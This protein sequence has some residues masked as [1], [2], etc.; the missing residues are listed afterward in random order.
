[1]A[2]NVVVTAGSGTTVAADEV[3]DGT[4]GTVKV[5]FV[6]LMDGTLDGTAKATIKAAS[7]AAAAADPAFVVALSPNNTALG[8]GATSAATIRTTL[9]SDSAGI[10]ATGTQASPSA[11]YLS[12]V[13][14]GDIAHDGVDSGNPQKIGAKATNVEPA[15]VSAS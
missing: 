7:T 11:A 2:D 5:Q 15:A 13:A 10:I 14:A 12:T 8:A 1:M 6:K 9:A 4:L 3:V